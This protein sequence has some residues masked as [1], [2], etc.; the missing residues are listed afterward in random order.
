[1][2]NLFVLLILSISLFCW[3]NLIFF[4]RKSFVFL[5]PFVFR[6]SQG[7]IPK[8]RAPVVNSPI[9]LFFFVKSFLHR[10]RKTQS[11]RAFWCLVAGSASRYCFSCRLRRMD[12]F[13]STSID[14]SH[15]R[16]SRK[17][18]HTSP[19]ADDTVLPARVSLLVLP[20]SFLRILFA[21]ADRILILFS[22]P[23]FSRY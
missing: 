10:F 14:G 22:L 19:T 15:R 21:K 13:P 1:M 3:K 20:F 18:V 17:D 16:F 4:T 2:N 8:K 11:G 7:L 23:Y 5:I 12:R 9:T 6:Y